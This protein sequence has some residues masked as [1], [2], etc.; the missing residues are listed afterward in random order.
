MTT[1]D[2]EMPCVYLPMPYSEADEDMNLHYSCQLK[3]KSFC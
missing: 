2:L 1:P 3:V